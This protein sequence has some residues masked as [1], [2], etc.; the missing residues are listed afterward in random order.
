MAVARQIDRIEYGGQ[1]MDGFGQSG[2][3]ITLC[4]VSLKPGIDHHQ[5]NAYHPSY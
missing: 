4:D 3:R 1:H 5:W 2:D